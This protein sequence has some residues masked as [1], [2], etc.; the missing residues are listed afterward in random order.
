M[1]KSAIKINQ[2]IHN[3][4]KKKYIH[5]STSQIRAAPEGIEKES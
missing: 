1:S 4:G 5:L 2:R 3:L